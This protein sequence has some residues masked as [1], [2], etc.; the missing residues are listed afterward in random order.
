[1]M[2]AEDDFAG[3]QISGTRE[4][5]DD[6]YGFCP[7]DANQD[8]IDGL[9]LV[10]ADGMGGYEG[11]ARASRLVTESFVDAFCRSTGTMQERLVNSLH[12]CERR[13]KQA[14]AQGEPRFAEMGSTLIGMVWTPESIRW[15]SVGD[16]AIYLYRGGEVKRV[17]EDHSLAPLLDEA[18]ERGELTP[19]Q[20]ATHPDRGLLR[21]AL[22]A[23]PL[24]LYE[25]RDLALLPSDVVIVASDG[26][27]TLKQ[28]KMEAKLEVNADQPA[29]R[30]ADALLVAVHEVRKAKQDNTTVAVIKHP[31]P[32]K[33]VKKDVERKTVAFNRRAAPTKP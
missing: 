17:N 2:K 21:A 5:Q 32:V 20:A 27:A 8:G 6:D 15:V 26:L 23:E 10:L 16:S 7:L 19:E 30:I 11:G 28:E 18:V 3:R 1:M 29:S 22:T 33:P 14:I 24:A 31:A 4:S 25:L 12:E 13:L 9:L